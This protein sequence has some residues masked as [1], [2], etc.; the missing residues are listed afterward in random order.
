MPSQYIVHARVPEGA[1][2]SEF[3]ASFSNAFKVSDS[4]ARAL[5]SKLPGKVSKPVTE[6]EARR[7]AK[8]FERIGLLIDI[9]DG[10][11]GEVVS[12]ASLVGSSSSSE[13][14]TSTAS[15]SI[16]AEAAPAGNGLSSTSVA[17][18]VQPAFP[19]PVANVAPSPDN[20]ALVPRDIP[21]LQHTPLPDGQAKNDIAAR[22]AKKAAAT[23]A[24][25]A[26]ISQ[27]VVVEDPAKA[28]LDPERDPPPLP[29]HVTAGQS[30]AVNDDERR[31]GQRGLGMYIS[32]LRGK[33][34]LAA[35]AAGLLA[36]LSGAVVATV[37]VPRILQQEQRAK[38]EGVATTFATSMAA[39]IARPLD[40]PASRNLLQR[41]L[42]QTQP[43]L[44]QNDVA[45]V[46]VTDTSAQVLAGWR[47]DRLS[48]LGL[49]AG[50]TGSVTT[51][52]AISAPLQGIIADEVTRASGLFAQ[53]QT[54]LR[55]GNQLLRPFGLPVDGLTLRT[56]AQ[57]IVQ[58]SEQGPNPVGVVVV[59]T[60]AETTG[61]TTRNL[62]LWLALASILP[63]VLAAL[64]ALRLASRVRRN[65]IS[66]GE[67]ASN[68]ELRTAPI[69]LTSGDEL[70]ELASTLE[71][72]RQR[73]QPAST[74]RTGEVT[75]IS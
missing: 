71:Q 68:L 69:D 31:A 57:M 39:L 36:V 19:S 20:I 30:A 15:S 70:E 51:N 6:R 8:R 58:A 2:P 33:F 72:T 23:Q 67:Q 44:I 1:S 42:E 12:I 60:F 47:D 14:S 41:W 56:S 52:N 37:L 64:L 34:V 21:A 22:E 65:V 17:D 4:R 26:S 24:L 43:L 13:A 63:L 28:G 3:I 35:L 38:T 46:V 5:I 18:V 55:L 11:S 40:D 54:T 59:G 61:R 7:L 9:I 10:D 50:T 25:A 49:D 45:M 48:L 74:T 53:Q 29:P 66:L 32:G 73:V 16:S 62:L 75:Q 27:T